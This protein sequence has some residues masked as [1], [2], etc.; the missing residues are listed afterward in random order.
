MGNPYNIIPIQYYIYYCYIV[1]NVIIDFQVSINKFFLSKEYNIIKS[2]C[3]TRSL[4]CFIDD[5]IWGLEL[6]CFMQIS[7]VFQL[8]RG[9]QFYWWRKSGVH[10]AIIGIRTHNFSG[11]RHYRFVYP[12]LNVFSPTL[13]CCAVW[14]WWF[15]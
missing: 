4:W 7:T 14:F 11:D 3:E 1:V 15:S 6:W 9:G 12:E 10:L 2:M 13:K 8:Y 5:I